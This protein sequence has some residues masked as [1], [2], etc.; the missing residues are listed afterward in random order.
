MTRQVINTGDCCRICPSPYYAVRPPPGK[1]GKHDS[2]KGGAGNDANN[3]DNEKD[4]GEKESGDKNTSKR[5]LL[6]LERLG[7]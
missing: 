4:D 3:D 7:E 1:L 2:R 5:R 6:S